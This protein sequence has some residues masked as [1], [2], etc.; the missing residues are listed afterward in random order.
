[1]DSDFIVSS[2]ARFEDQIGKL[3]C[4]HAAE[5]MASWPDQSV[6]CIITSPPYGNAV[7]YDGPSGA[8]VGKGAILKI[9]DPKIVFDGTDM[10]GDV[11]LTLFGM[12]GSIEKHFIRARQRRGI[13][14]AKLR[15]AYKGRPAT[16]D[17]QQVRELREQGLGATEI[18]RRLQIGRASVYRALAA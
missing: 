2:D 3:I 1:M 9:D 10:M 7:E 16:I 15:G 11:L 18:A 4:G 5:V 17:P 12:V 6:D 8:V 14:A 13:E